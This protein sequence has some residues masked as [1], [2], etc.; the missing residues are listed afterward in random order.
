MLAALLMFM[1]YPEGD[2]VTE[3]NV[4]IL[5]WI[6][7]L[8]HLFCSIHHPLKRYRVN[9]AANLT[10]VFSILL[11]VGQGYLTI[12]STLIVINSLAAEKTEH[13]SKV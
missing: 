2:T 4:R 10:S 12:I 3:T 13:F 7:A 5:W 8:F 1:H 9:W 11:I 6:S